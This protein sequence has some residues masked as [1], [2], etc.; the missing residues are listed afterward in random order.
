MG[1]EI[2][3]QIPGFGGIYEVSSNGNVRRWKSGAKTGV[4]GWRTLKPN[5]VRGYRYFVLSLNGRARSMRGARLVLMAFV[6][7]PLSSQEA[8]HCNGDRSDDRVVNLRWDTRSSNHADKIEHGTDQRCERHPCAKLTLD[9]ARMVFVAQ[10]RQKEIAA[11]F[12]IS[13]ATVSAIKTGRLWSSADLGAR[14]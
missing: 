13:Q 12:G 11:K 10:G 1:R 2:W 8:C 5:V 7:M 3:K 9:Q 4:A 14:A 6:G